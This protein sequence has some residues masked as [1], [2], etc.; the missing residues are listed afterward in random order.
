MA[1]MMQHMQ[2]LTTAAESEREALEVRVQT[3]FSR[4]PEDRVHG[5]G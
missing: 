2:P 5:D 4:H 1:P 3:K